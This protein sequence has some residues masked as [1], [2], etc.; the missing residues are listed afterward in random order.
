MS[1]NFFMVRLIEHWNRLPRDVLGS[2]SLETFKTF[3]DMFLCDLIQVFLL[4]Q[5]DWTR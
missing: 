5:G 1:K 4:Q 3:L 2:P